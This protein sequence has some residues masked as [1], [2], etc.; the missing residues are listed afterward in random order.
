V[1]A[2]CCR[3]VLPLIPW[4]DLA[5]RPDL[6]PLKNGFVCF[7]TFLTRYQ[8][9]FRNK[10]GLHAGFRH[11]LQAS[12]FEAIMLADG[13]LRETL[14]LIPGSGTF[15]GSEQFR[16]ALEAQGKVITPQQSSALFRFT[17]TSSGRGIR[18][19]DFLGSL[20]LNFAVLHP[21][22]T[23][24]ANKFV[25]DKL[26]E[27]AREILDAARLRSQNQHKASMESIAV[28]LRNWFWKAD[29]SQNGYLEVDE[30][31]KAI[32]SLVCCRSLTQDRLTAIADFVDLS[33]DGRI[34]YAELLSALCVRQAEGLKLDYGPGPAVLAE[35]ILETA[36][37]ALHFV[38]ARPLRKLL[39]RMLPAGSRRCGARMFGR[40]LQVINS[41]AD[42]KLLTERQMSAL[43]ESLDTEQTGLDINDPWFDFEDFFASFRIIDTE[44]E[45]GD[46][47]EPLA[48]SLDAF[49][50]GAPSA[51]RVP[52][53]ATFAA[54]SEARAAA[55]SLAAASS[56]PA[57]ASGIAGKPVDLAAAA[58]CALALVADPTAFG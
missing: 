45:N 57:A 21:R 58:K 39:R 1:W 11:K 19:E 44:V 43:V 27:I 55:R 5:G 24:D 3:Q 47:D 22:K 35:D 48:R 2:A 46:E 37:H 4:E 51:P 49:S 38:Y 32:R 18:V 41:A 54:L 53:S 34:N 31:I 15:V 12:L 28:I 33:G 7:T 52:A 40:A 23:T 26:D 36:Y 56:A 30:F 25:P 10:F 13:T 17:L 20:S 6:V 9:L 50:V 42:T 8:V 14:G 29:K 16:L